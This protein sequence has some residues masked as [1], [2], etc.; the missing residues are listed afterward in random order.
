MTY[1]SVVEMAG[2]DSLISRVAAAAADE[3]FPD[4]PLSFARLNI[5]KIVAAG[6]DWAAAWDSARA[7]GSDNVNPD[8]GARD[9]VITDAMILAT[10]QP[11]VQNTAAGL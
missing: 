10:V 7:S 8:T 11:M 6:S 1:Q 3:G 4:D 5:W 9:D 2:S